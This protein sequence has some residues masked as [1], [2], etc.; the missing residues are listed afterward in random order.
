MNF[1]MFFKR[2]KAFFLRLIYGKNYMKQPKISLLIPFSSKDP[3]RQDT[4]EWLLEYWSYELPD[5]EVI[6]GKCKSKIFCKGEALNNAVGKSKGKVLVV[7][8]ADAYMDGEVLDKC[9]DTILE[10]LAYGNKMWYVPYRN[11]YRLTKEATELVTSSDPWDS[12]RFPTSMDLEYVE[13][14]DI[15][16]RSKYGARYGAMAMMFPREAYDI[17]GC[18]DERFKGWGGE[19]IALLRAIDTLFGKHKTSNNDIYH[20]WHPMIGD[21]PK[22]KMWAG[23]DSPNPNSWLASRYNRVTGKPAE[24]RK[25]VDEGCEYKKNKQ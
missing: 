10:E 7:L 21:S 15:G 4:F 12:F 3:V 1:S 13:D 9:A 18:F 5:A 20:L 11:L 22:N 14:K 8:D 2:L 16:Y 6:V 24:M 23:Q 17:L 19:D 25:L